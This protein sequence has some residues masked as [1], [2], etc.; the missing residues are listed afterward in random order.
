MTPPRL[1][2][3]G[4]GDPPKQSQAFVPRP[5]PARPGAVE[6]ALQDLWS[7][8]IRRRLYRPQHWKDLWFLRRQ[9]DLDEMTPRELQLDLPVGKLPDCHN[10]VNTCCTGPLRV[11][12]LRL[13]D[14]AA[15]MDAGL[16]DHITL[17]KPQF[18]AQ[19]LAANAP[20]ADVVNSEAWQSMPVIRQDE[21]RTC[22][23]LTADNQCGA[24]PFWPLS[25]ARFPYAMDILNQRI[26]YARGCASVQQD[27]TRAGRKREGQLVDAVVE[28]YNQ[29]IRDA[30][31]LRVARPE[32]TELG[33]MQHVR[34]P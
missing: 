17:D 13:V 8:S 6:R 10:C 22:T 11:V 9:Y 23:L 20:L 5:L 31:L 18:T 28:A 16:V 14:V 30:V 4:G 29:R 27:A 3:L 15:F 32:L 24:H 26:F 33:L 1:R 34:F 21:T 25:C 7:P 12:L 2:L 19:E